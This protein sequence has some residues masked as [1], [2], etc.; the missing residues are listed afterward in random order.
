[1]SYLDARDLCRCQQ[2][3]KTWRIPSLD[4]DLWRRQYNILTRALSTTR[5]VLP[6]APAPAPTTPSPFFSI[7]KP[8]PSYHALYRYLHT[9][10]QNWT[11]S[12]PQYT[13][14]LSLPHQKVHAV[15]LRDPYLAV[16]YASPPELWVYDLGG[17]SE[18]DRRNKRE[19]WWWPSVDTYHTYNDDLLLRPAHA[20][21]ELR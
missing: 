17:K 20:E 13:I 9:R 6:P 1:M 12:R 15:R 19:Q 21:G 18:L 16:V 2:V 10:D 7:P 8:L 11:H 3:C 4:P 5:R 14:P